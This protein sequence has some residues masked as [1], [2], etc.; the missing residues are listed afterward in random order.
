MEKPKIRTLLYKLDRLLDRYVI[1]GK[2]AN[3]SL[4]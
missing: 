2:K 4:L 1:N 3:N